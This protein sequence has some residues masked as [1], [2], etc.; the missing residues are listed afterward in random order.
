MEQ[1]IGNLVGL[2]IAQNVLIIIKQLDVSHNAMVLTKKK[3]F[4]FYS[5]FS[6]TVLEFP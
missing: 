1:L 4:P 6:Q 2:V 3:G 5:Q